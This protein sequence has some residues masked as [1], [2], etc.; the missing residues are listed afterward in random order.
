VA[1]VKVVMGMVMLR[2]G[3]G[4]GPPAA[5]AAAARVVFVGRVEVAVGCVVLL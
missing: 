4:L 1:P 2:F 3:I 5:A